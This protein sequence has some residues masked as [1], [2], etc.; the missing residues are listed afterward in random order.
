MTGKVLNVVGGACAKGLLS[1][2]EPGGNSG[3]ASEVDH[4]GC[5]INVII[6][7][8]TVIRSAGQ[9]FSGDLPVCT[10]PNTGKC[11]EPWSLP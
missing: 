1:L 2:A 11:M 7:V 3:H 6:Y 4:S 10:A 5:T 9:G 8:G